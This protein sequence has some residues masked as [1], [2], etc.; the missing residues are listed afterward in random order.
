MEMNYDDKELHQL[1]QELHTEILPGTEIMADVGSHHFVKSSGKD[2]RVL[3]PQPSD[4]PHDP[5]NWSTGW[6]LSAIIASSFVS[7]MQGM[8]PLSLAP[9][10]GDYIE[11][12][13]CSLA[14]AVQFTG[15]AILV[16]GFSN[17]IWV[18]LSTSFGRRPVYIASQL[19]CLGSSIW[20]AKAQTYGSF[21]GACVLNGIG[22]GPAETIQPAVIADIFFLHDRGKWNTLY[23]VVYMGS[24]M[25]GPIIAG[26]MSL[27][28]G[29]RNFWWLNTGLLGLSL[30]MVIFMFPE[31]KW[32]RQ[33]PRE[34]HHE[35]NNPTDGKPTVEAREGVKGEPLADGNDAMAIAPQPLTTVET[36]ARDPYLGKG[37][38][39]RAQWGLYTPN[40]TPIK[41]ILL[42][43]WIPW[44][45]FTF[46][47]VEFA[48]FVVSW[49][50]SSFLTLNLTQTQAFAAPPYNFSTQSIGFTNFAV[51][52]GALIGLFTAGPLS[53][54][55]S[56]RL[57]NRNRGIRE[58]E[59]RLLAMVPYVIIMY[60][61]NIIVSV[62]YQH[63]WPWQ[64]I[65]IIGYTCAGIQV[66]ALPGIVS[67]Y[68]VDSYKPV[69]GSL[70]VSITVNKNVWGYGFSKF[71]TTWIVA[72]GY[73]PPIMT[74]ASLILLWC[75]FGILFYYK[76]KT[77]R[78]WTKNSSV[79]MM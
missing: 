73:I 32:H 52:V 23:W 26:S 1:E 13:H 46:P 2:H 44:K 59:M 63:Q 5:L 58:P 38:P 15:V 18:P 55:V 53:D 66:A 67:T 77:F 4:N 57:T 7:F 47:I 69:A 14:D 29:W 16:L 51:F 35:G 48:S 60:L 42:D 6:K 12:F 40:P 9:M 28:V 30:L 71:I 11:A 20:R 3:V 39:S 78:R 34:L 68:A 45:L 19:I 72:D 33:H 61:G 56:A 65:V 50:C 8:G 74:N 70:F 21:M 36:A 54:W 22:A 75:L 25:I 10:F 17:F 43:L 24:L 31:T 41:S 27:H 62:G 64:A 79:H 49:S 37:G 76:G